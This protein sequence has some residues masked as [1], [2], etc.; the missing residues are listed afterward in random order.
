MFAFCLIFPVCIDGA[1]L[2]RSFE[3]GKLAQGG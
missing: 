3:A 2:P 1:S